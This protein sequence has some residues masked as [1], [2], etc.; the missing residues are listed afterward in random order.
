MFLIFREIHQ[1]FPE[2][3][4]LT[5][6]EFRHA[7]ARRLRPG[8]SVFVGDGRGRRLEYTLGATGDQLT[9]QSAGANA[10]VIFGSEPRVELWTAVPEGKRWDWLL[11]K[12]TE[13]GATVIQPIVTQHSEARK[14]KRDREEKIILEAAVQSRRFF[15][16]ELREPVALAKAF[17]ERNQA[18]PSRAAT[19]DPRG[20]GT[21][22]D[23]FRTDDVAIAEGPVQ[24]FVGPE[25]GFS[26][27][28]L[29]ELTAAGIE[30]ATLG[31]PSLR[32]ETAAVAALAIFTAWSAGQR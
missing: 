24:I 32:V 15:L 8:D 27:A 10:P 25:G 6:E 4:P 7:R 16:P 22:F 29:R 1:S 2:S 30:L 26:E 28:E 21:L 11:Q 5:P 31:T 18:A 13:L 14:I 19:L 3:I 12:A 9:A 20:D 17:D 23:F